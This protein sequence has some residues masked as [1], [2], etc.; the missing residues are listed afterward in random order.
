MILTLEYRISPN[1]E[2]RALMLNWLELLRVHWNYA[3]GQRLDWLYGT[4]CLIDRCSLVSEPIGIIPERPS[5]YTQCGELKQTKKLFP[6]YKTVYSQVQQQ[7]LMRLDKAWQRWLIPNKSGKRSGRPR[8]KKAGDLRSFTYPQTN[9]YRAGVTVENNKI[10]FGKIGEMPIILH[11][12]I[13]DGFSLKTCTVIKKADGWYVLLVAEDSS[14]PS[15]LPMDTIKTVAGIDLGLKEFLVTSE[16]QAVPIQQQFRKNQT[17]LGKLQKRLSKKTLGSSNYKKLSKKVSCLNQHIA[18]T[19]KE[20]HYLTAHKLCE[21]YDLIGI[22]DL[23]IRALTKTR[24]AKSI[25]DAAWGQFSRILET[26][27][28]IRGNWIVKVNPYGTSQKCSGCGENVPKDLSVRMH[29]CPHCG[30]VLD[31]DHNAAINIKNL[32]LNAVG[33]TV[34]ACGDL[35]VTQSMNQEPLSAKRRSEKVRCA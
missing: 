27:A 21:K 20:F 11:R 17:K 4:R 1:K 3:L 18:R 10:K 33:L 26:V 24:L 22:E 15:P 12:P 32:A 31:R 5:H 30:T 23:N 19:R 13:P 6:E 34:S 7:N 28:V 25:F 14:V 2:Q 9:C 8:F 29:N 16:G 35:E